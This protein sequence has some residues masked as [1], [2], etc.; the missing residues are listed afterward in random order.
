MFSARPGRTGTAE[1]GETTGGHLRDHVALMVFNDGLTFF[2]PDVEGKNGGENTCE[3]AH[4]P[5]FNKCFLFV[6]CVS[7]S[8]KG[9]GAL[10][11]ARK[12]CL[13][14]RIRAALSRTWRMSFFSV[15]A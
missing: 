9:S 8:R 2:S 12:S 13:E 14:R 3:F 6:K 15:Y 10:L 4:G 11:A 7:I 5:W 1:S